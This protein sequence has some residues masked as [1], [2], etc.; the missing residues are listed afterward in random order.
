MYPGRTGNAWLALALSVVS[1]A[2][3]SWVG[4]SAV[5]RGAAELK[6][7]WVRSSLMASWYALVLAVV[8]VIGS[9]QHKQQQVQQQQPGDDT[10]SALDI[11]R[12]A[13]GPLLLAIAAW[14]LGSVSGR[15]VEHSARYGLVVTLHE[16]LGKDPDHQLSAA[17][18]LKLAAVRWLVERW[19]QPPTFSAPELRE[20]LVRA[21]SSIALE[22]RLFGSTVKKGD[23]GG[24]PSGSLASTGSEKG[25]EH[26]GPSIP[27]TTE[28]VLTEWLQGRAPEPPMIRLELPWETSKPADVAGWTRLSLEAVILLRACPSSCVMSAVLLLGALTGAPWG[29]CCGWKGWA[30]ILPLVG[31]AVVEACRVQ[32]LLTE[33]RQKRKARPLHAEPPAK[34]GTAAGT[35]AGD[36]SLFLEQVNPR[37]ANVWWNA[38]RAVEKLR[39]EGPIPG[40]A[41]GAGSAGNAGVVDGFEGVDR[42]GGSLDGG[43]RN[44]TEGGD[45]PRAAFVEG[46]GGPV[47]AE[48][49]AL[50]AAVQ[51]KQN[52]PRLDSAAR[53]RAER[54]VGQRPRLLKDYLTYSRPRSA[55]S[56]VYP[57]RFTGSR[58]NNSLGLGLSRPLLGSGSPGAPSTVSTAATA[59]AAVRDAAPAPADVGAGSVGGGEARIGV[60]AHGEGG[61]AAVRSLSTP[62]LLEAGATAAAVELPPSPRARALPSRLPVPPPEEE[63]GRSPPASTTPRAPEGTA[64]LVHREEPVI[65]PAAAP[66]ASETAAAAA[67]AAAARTAADQAAPASVPVERAA[68]AA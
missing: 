29:S 44:G 62:P 30:F 41:D 19:S 33:L 40:D 26:P 67:A 60:E 28:R 38:L 23:N 21:V 36:L 48:A 52:S 68:A 11:V 51:E 25:R 13:P 22:R 1:V 46:T 24:S 15:H 39:E 53:K 27:P 50:L 2:Y 34:A 54:V 6:R 3:T 59:A 47:V 31:P 61:G 16:A 64:D 37:L 65:A 12:R 20:M 45:T 14:Q 9:Q 43:G 55:D 49:A 56:P 66:P 32:V 5:V 57:G 63:E 10:M 58:T 35:A 4:V 18:L 8:A 17:S 7:G 42:G